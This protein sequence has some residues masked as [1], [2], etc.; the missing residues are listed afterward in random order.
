MRN[1][2]KWYCEKCCCLRVSKDTYKDKKLVF[3]YYPGDDVYTKVR[4]CKKCSN[5]VVK[6]DL[7]YLL[8]ENKRLCID[9]NELKC[10][11]RCL[12][13]HI[14]YIRRFGGVRVDG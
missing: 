7:E 1:K 2:Y 11:I 14:E 5:E 3:H 13:S 6:I 4:K 12:E 10:S 9:V 8:N